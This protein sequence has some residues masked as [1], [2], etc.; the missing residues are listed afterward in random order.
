MPQS[1]H[2]GVPL[3]AREPA[4][5]GRKALSASVLRASQAG[6]PYT[7]SIFLHLFAAFTRVNLADSFN[8]QRTDTHTHKENA[9]CSESPDVMRLK[10]VKDKSGL[11][12]TLPLS[13]Y[14]MVQDCPCNTAKLSQVVSPPVSRTRPAQIGFLH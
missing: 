10:S 11:E 12:R 8:L 4:A 6:P 9:V 5:Q 1:V 13:E 3:C 2:W 7:F 14:T